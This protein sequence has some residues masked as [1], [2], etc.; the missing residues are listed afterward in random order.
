MLARLRP[1]QIVGD[2]A[3][4]HGVAV[5]D[6]VAKG[7][8][9]D[10]TFFVQRVQLDDHGVRTVRDLDVL[11]DALEVLLFG[12]VFVQAVDGVRVGWETSEVEDLGVE[13]TGGGKG[14]SEVL[15]AVEFDLDEGGVADDFDEVE[16]AV[17][18]F[19]AADGVAFGG[20]VEDHADEEF[21]LGEE[22]GDVR[23]V[24]GLVAGFGF[25][26]E[27]ED[28]AG[29]LAGSDEHR[30]VQNGTDGTA[31]GVTDVNLDR[32]GGCVFVAKGC[33]R[34]VVLAGVTQVRPLAVAGEG[35]PQI[36]TLAVGV[37]RVGFALGR[38]RTAGVNVVQGGELL[39]LSGEYE[40]AVD[41]DVFHASDEAGDGPGNV[42]EVG[43]SEGR[44][45]S[46]EVGDG[47]GGIASVGTFVRVDREDGLL[48]V[49]R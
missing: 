8:G 13:L 20:V 46:S 3:L 48:F 49:G 26:A 31:G 40:L 27:V 36:G 24:R 43:L 45:G 14:F 17:V 11:D 41:D 23:V 4:E 33:R 19:V 15:G 10:Q 37:A 25:A 21:A 1:A 16:I 22:R 2:D 38:S 35:V 28:H 47:E 18:E 9:Q 29:G 30:D 42:L 6:N 39:F 44:S 5:D 34:D 32:G 7:W 12:V